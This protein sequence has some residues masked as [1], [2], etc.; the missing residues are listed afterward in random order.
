MLIVWAGLLAVFIFSAQTIGQSPDSSLRSIHN[1]DIHNGTALQEYAASLRR[2]FVQKGGSRS[3]PGMSPNSLAGRLRNP[4][5]G[6]E[7]E[8]RQD[9]TCETCTDNKN[10]CFPADS[11][12][13]CSNCGVCCVADK[14][15][16]CNFATAVCCPGDTDGCCEAYQTCDTGVGCR[17]PTCVYPPSLCCSMHQ[18]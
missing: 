7:L 18:T 9:C 13:Y 5:E 11:E 15:Y 4:F 3:M 8:P 1:V 10:Y 16:C 17:D 6:L 2:L 12:S 14:S